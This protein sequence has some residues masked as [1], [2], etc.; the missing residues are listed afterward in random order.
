MNTKFSRVR[1][2]LESFWQP[3]RRRYIHIVHLWQV[4]RPFSCSLS[5]IYG[6]DAFRGQDGDPTIR[7]FE[8]ILFLHSFFFLSEGIYYASFVLYKT[9]ELTSQIDYD[10]RFHKKFMLLK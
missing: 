9:G 4:D 5:L 10:N 8:P 3:G 6:T 1:T 2:G 7:I